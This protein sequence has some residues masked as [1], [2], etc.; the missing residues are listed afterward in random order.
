MQREE[1]TREGTV[2]EHWEDRINGAR[3]G[4]ERDMNHIIVEPLRRDKENEG[5]NGEVKE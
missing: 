2:E 3:G 4:G 5:K 1:R